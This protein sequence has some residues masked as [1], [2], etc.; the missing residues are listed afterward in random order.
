MIPVNLKEHSSSTTGHRLKRC[1][2]QNAFHQDFSK[3]LPCVG[4]PL[5]TSIFSSWSLTLPLY[6][7]RVF[8]L[9]HWRTPGVYM[10]FDVYHWAKSNALPSNL[11]SQGGI[12]YLR[13]RR[14]EWSYEGVYWT[15]LEALPGRTV[16]FGA[17]PW[18]ATRRRRP[19]CAGKLQRCRQKNGA[20]ACR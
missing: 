1:N 19:G 2:K 4:F 8:N 13:Q 3:N 11:N 12:W 5:E 10:T 14:R 7:A 6:I 16:D 17:A 20:L 18:W 15:E 9:S